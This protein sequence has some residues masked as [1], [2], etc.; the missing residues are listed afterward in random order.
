LLIQQ[1]SDDL[2]PNAIP[3]ET[4]RHRYYTPSVPH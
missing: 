2:A 3:G 1:F 4:P